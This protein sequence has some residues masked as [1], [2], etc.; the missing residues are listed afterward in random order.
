M[1]RIIA[2]VGCLPLAFPAVVAEV[3]LVEGVVA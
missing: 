3:V 1:K 2:K